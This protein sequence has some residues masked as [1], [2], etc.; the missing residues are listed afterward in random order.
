MQ[1][2]GTGVLAVG[3][4]I[5]LPACAANTR[6]PGCYR[7]SLRLAPRISVRPQVGTQGL[8][9]LVLDG[10]SNAPVAGAT[11]VV[12]PGQRRDMTDSLGIS[13]LSS[14]SGQVH[15]LVRAIGYKRTT[16]TLSIP[17]GGGRFLIV[18]LQPDPVC[19][20]EIILGL[21][22]LRPSTR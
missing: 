10:S 3:L 18:Q 1:R 6:Q 21:T 12:T 2:L 7:P 11:L 8:T 13:Q 9:V 14:L 20:E 17:I 15:L 22:L 5:S 4:L 19:L 16:D